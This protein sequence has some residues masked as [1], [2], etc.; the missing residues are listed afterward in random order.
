MRRLSGVAFLQWW[1]AGCTL[2]IGIVLAGCGGNHGSSSVL[3]AGSQLLSNTGGDRSRA[4][5]GGTGPQYVQSFVANSTSGTLT[6]SILV[7]LGTSGSAGVA[8]SSSD[9]LIMIVTDSGNGTNQ[10]PTAPSAPWVTITGGSGST[11]GWSTIDAYRLPAGSAIPASVTIAFGHSAVGTVSEL[12]V[13]NSAGVEVVA[14]G[15]QQ[16]TPGSSPWDATTGTGTASATGELPIVAGVVDDSLNA[17]AIT[18]YTTINSA[19]LHGDCCLSYGQAAVVA[20]GA[21]TTS[22][23]ITSTSM[24]WTSGAGS[25]HTLGMK[26][27]IKPAA[28]P[29]PPPGGSPGYVQSFAAAMPSAA[30]ATSLTVT[31]GT[32]GS[33]H[34]APS[35]LHDL[36]AVVQAWGNAANATH[37]AAPSG[38]TA[39]SGATLATTGWSTIDAFRL[40][41]GSTIPGSVT[42]N[43]FGGTNASVLATVTIV[44]ASNSA[45][46]EAVAAGGVVA[47]QT[48]S[49]ASTTG[50]GTASSASELPIIVGN[51]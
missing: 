50:S 38:W 27:L 13:S 36:I 24:G 5:S 45:G 37:A 18:G 8:P 32:S 19:S 40:P 3:P 22:T 46:V 21:Q 51:P 23:T 6:S 14:S 48:S 4:M 20:Y 25:E 16:A 15:G 10:H 33:A 31:L 2:A 30:P 43:N 39:I 35:S 42:F 11:T 9:D 28:P 26:L 29:T 17:S 1:A 41:S 47:T 34:T 12:E 44:E 7:T 49:Y